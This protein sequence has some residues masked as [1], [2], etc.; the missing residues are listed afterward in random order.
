MSAFDGATVLIV[1]EDP[2]Q[3]ERLSAALA[4]E[5]GRVLRV[6]NETEAINCL[7]STQVDILIAPLRSPHVDG[8]K[9][10]RLAQDLY[11]HTAVILMV[12]SDALEADSAV[13]LMLDG[14]NDTLTRPVNT[15]RLR[16]I[17]RRILRQQEIVRER[18]SLRT[19]LQHPAEMLGFTARLA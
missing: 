1:D 11:E 3:R 14:A 17:V 7:M 5:A 15:E 12:D 13:R 6:Q 2:R 18:D 9:L 4:E 10:L 8:G 19:Q 16:A